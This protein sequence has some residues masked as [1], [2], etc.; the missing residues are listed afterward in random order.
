M[1]TPSGGRQERAARTQAE[2]GSQKEINASSL[3]SFDG[4]VANH[5]WR[6]P[7]LSN[8]MEM[9]AC[10]FLSAF[11]ASFTEVSQGRE[12][13]ML[14][15]W[16]LRGDTMYG[17]GRGAT[18]VTNMRSEGGVGQLLQSVLSTHCASKLNSGLRVFT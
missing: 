6:A 15:V 16:L 5:L 7:P 9:G 2:Q 18:M 11:G 13:V 14:V 12:K 8:N 1:R 17:C 4:Q 3:L 10:Y